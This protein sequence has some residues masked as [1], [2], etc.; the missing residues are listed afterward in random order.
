MFAK[1][2]LQL[3]LGV[4]P[5]LPLAL[6]DEHRVVQVVGNLLSNARKYTPAGG[7]V[8]VTLQRAADTGEL[9]LTVS[10]NG[11]GIGPEDHARIGSYLFQAHTANSISAKGIGLGLYIT[12]SLIEQHGG[13]FWFES[14]PGQ[15]SAFHVTFLVA[16]AASQKAP[17]ALLDC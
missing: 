15:G 2:E 6:L 9:L 12:R 11:I 4:E 8:R 7:V 13:R 16:E 14:S 5:D 1:A 3:N 10:D 17:D